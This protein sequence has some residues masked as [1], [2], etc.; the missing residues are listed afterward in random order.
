MKLLTQWFDENAKR[1][2]DD[3]GIAKTKTDSSNYDNPPTIE[4]LRVLARP[5]LLHAGW[6]IEIRGS[7]SRPRFS[8]A[9]FFWLSSPNLN[10]QMRDH[11]RVS[12]DQMAPQ[13]G[14]PFVEFGLRH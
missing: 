12:I 13:F 14:Q 11:Q 7:N 4:K 5:G 10:E 3:G 9:G 2:D 8:D 1:I 6:L